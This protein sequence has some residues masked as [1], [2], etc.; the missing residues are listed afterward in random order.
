MKPAQK[1]GG[2]AGRAPLTLDAVV[3][4]ALAIVNEDGLE[5]LS[6]RKL[7]ARLGVEAMTLYYYVANKEAL[8]DRL[9]ER[10]LARA[11]D[12]PI[13]PDAGWREQLEQFARRYRAALLERPNL[14]AL[15][16]VRPARSPEALG[17][18]AAAG[19]ALM[20]AGFSLEEG[21]HIGNAIAML[22]IGA[23]LAEIGS[24]SPSLPAAEVTKDRSGFAAL[25]ADQTARVHD[26]EAIFDFALESLLN[27]VA[28]K[29]VL[30]RRE[31]AP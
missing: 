14:I 7:G 11:I 8:L 9:V 27:G 6:M 26:H 30:G 4:A 25:M 3:D 16:A 5:S 29:L 15:I 19:A 20:K 28:L 24:S 23:A 21:F 31:R 17:R 10:V 18:L 12:P 1:P 22:V 13:A 2:R